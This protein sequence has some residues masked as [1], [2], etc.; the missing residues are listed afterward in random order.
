MVTDQMDEFIELYNPTAVTVNLS[1]YTVSDNQDAYGLGT[2]LL[3]PGEILAL[4]RGTTG[5]V[6]SSDEAVTL[7]YPNGTVLDVLDYPSLKKGWTFQRSPDGGDRARTGRHP[8]PGG[9]NPVPSIVINEVMPDP[10]G[11]N[12]GEQWV[13][14]LNRGRSEELKDMVLTNNEALSYILPSFDIAP[15]ERVLI[16]MGRC[17]ALP[18]HPNMTRTLEASLTE[19]LYSSGD[20]LEL[21]DR[22]GSTL[23][24]IAWGVSKHIEG[25]KGSLGSLSWDGKVWDAISGSMSDKG[26]PNPS[27]ISNKSLSRSPDG[28]DTD[29]TIDLTTHMGFLGSSPGWENDIDP[30]ILFGAVPDRIEIEKGGAT[31]LS[32][33]LSAS[34][35]MTGA[36]ELDQSLSNDNWTLVGPGGSEY[37]LGPGEVLEVDVSLS[38][39]AD[40]AMGHT[41][42]LVLRAAWTSWEFLTS[43]LMID[44]VIP[45][46]ELYLKDLYCT[47][48]GVTA[49]MVPEGALIDVGGKLCG[50]GEVP[51]PEAAVSVSIFNT[52]SGPSAPSAR[53]NSVVFKDL[54]VTSRRSF[55]FILD[56][57]GLTG[58]TSLLLKIDP[59]DLIEESDE[60]NNEAL[61]ELTV[62][63]AP[64]FQGQG[65]LRLSEVLWNTTV[66]GCFVCIDNTGSSPAE[67]SGFMLGNGDTVA[68]FPNDCWLGPEEKALVIWGEDAEGRIPAGSNLFRMDGKGLVGNRMTLSSGLPDLSRSG[69]LRLLT[70]WRVPVDEVL[71][72]RGGGSGD[73]CLPLF[74]GPVETTY[75]TVLKRARALDGSF[76]DTNTTLDW[77]VEPMNAGIGA[78]LI[79]PKPGGSGEFLVIDGMDVDVDLSGAC[80]SCRGRVAV[81]PN[82]TRTGRDGLISVSKDP[83]QFRSVQGVDP[84]LTTGWEVSSV[85]GTIPGCRVTGYEELLLPNDNAELLLLDRGNRLLDRVAWGTD[86]TIPIGKAPYDTVLWRSFP[87]SGHTGPWRVLCRGTDPAYSL[88]GMGR[89]PITF[90][91]SLG[92]L[93]LTEIADGDTTVQLYTPYL[94]EGD[95]LDLLLNVLGTGTE[96]EV[97]LGCQPWEDVGSSGVQASDGD[98]VL[99]AC[100]AVSDSG[101]RLFAPGT[102]SN[103][104]QYTPFLVSGNRTV[105]LYDHG[106]GPDNY[107]DPILPSVTLELGDNTFSLPALG[108]MMPDLEM[109]DI[110]SILSSMPISLSEAGPVDVATSFETPAT[111]LKGMSCTF[112]SQLDTIGGGPEKEV[113]VLHN[114]GPLDVVSLLDLAKEGSV[115]R[116][117]LNPREVHPSSPGSEGEPASFNEVP[118]HKLDLDELER[119]VLEDSIR[120][121]RSASEQG[122]D[123]EARVL[124]VECGLF[125][126]SG[127]QVG[128]GTVQLELP[129]AGDGHRAA[130]RL[131]GPGLSVFN[132]VMGS[133]WA[134][135]HQLPLEMGWG[136]PHRDVEGPSPTVRVQEVFPDTYLVDDP[137]EYVALMNTGGSAVD[138]SGW[139]LSDDEGIGLS[140]DGTV[141]LPEGSVVGPGAMFFIARDHQCFLQQNGHIPDLSMHNCSLSDRVLIC[142]GDMRL[143]NNGDTILLRDTTGTV[144]DSVIYGSSDPLPFGGSYSPAGSWSGPPAPLPGWGNILHREQRTYGGPSSDTGTREDWMGLRPRVPGQSRFGPFTECEVESISTGYCPDSGSDLLSSII[145][146]SGR[147]LD[148][149]VYELTSE[150]VTSAL[151]GAVARGVEVRVIMEGSPVGGRTYGSDLRVNE[152][153]LSGAKVRYMTMDISKGIRDRYSYDH[154]KYMVSD[155][156]T[157]LISSDN[158]KD[159]SFPLP[160]LKGAC[161]GTRGWVML[162]ESV[163]LSQQLAAVFEEDWNGPDMVDGRTVIGEMTAPEDGSAPSE[164]RRGEGL[165]I[166]GGSTVKESAKA[167]L[168]ISPDHISLEGNRLLQAIDGAEKE[169]LVEAMS[170]D[171]DYLTIGTNASKVREYHGL[172]IPGIAWPNPYVTALLEAAM[173]GVDIKV[174][175]DGSDF[176]GDS[177]PDNQRTVDSL[178]EAA[179]ELDMLDRFHVRL[180]PAE[181]PDLERKID[182]VHNKGMVIDSRMVWTSSFNIG[183]TSALKNREVGV[184]VTSEKVS[185]LFRSV[186]MFDWGGTLLGEDLIR[187]VHYGPAGASRT[188]GVKVEL[189]LNGGSMPEAGSELVIVPSLLWDRDGPMVDGRTM[190]GTDDINGTEVTLVLPDL[191]ISEPNELDLYLLSGERWA[192]ILRFKVEP[193]DK[194]AVYDQAPW[195]GNDLV[196][197]LGSVVLAIAITAFLELFLRRSKRGKGPKKERKEEE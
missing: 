58:G 67:L 171:I 147:S 29:R 177:V 187:S 32:V 133:L 108:W 163:P 178:L 176:D 18:P 71:L 114:G 22:D 182:F 185:E 44:L 57:L 146:G 61:W 150:W 174:L 117:L 119:T 154:A 193:F 196:P 170:M 16:A 143:S 149:N 55:S 45:S 152:L 162:L 190:V 168:L 1:G 100:R 94:Q 11:S 166:F 35:N 109:V 115:V 65:S 60:M 27:A 173:R 23:D 38:A 9:S 81:L 172:T 83:D 41:C 136:T 70:R 179:G 161:S 26:F 78:L 5:L 96:V 151:T 51:C 33:M 74:G 105:I 101:G 122:L 25:P 24:Y 86:D 12:S 129:S 99:R 31:T 76:I 95:L 107:D 183:P 120:T 30:T 73:G 188:K 156:R 20:D 186:F 54:T 191:D 141:M 164:D 34:F 77:T 82:G 124:P 194:D 91:L 90:D 93:D 139:T 3:G 123:L 175:L 53:V 72:H 39:P 47:F 68:S 116:L 167:T 126:W 159:S 113:W 69:S 125:D 118:S 66:S 195:Y 28:T 106:R 89:G 15:G 48:E 140:S 135:S 192:H 153:L 21:K 137:D 87:E 56:T 19:T 59:F 148:V 130:L 7:R 165:Y 4:F 142:R 63:P 8:T 84:D 62:Y 184:L 42:R 197:L 134:D 64:S 111:V 181:R 75:G 138:I 13:E 17:D 131:S 43:C 6:L 36:L 157:V 189:T 14:L 79:S 103:P 127:L 40:L 144:V 88:F 110:T 158:L 92:S 132:E 160:L 121:V 128:S 102:A 112:R 85:S 145:A 97:F 80:L 104:D 49:G 169:V 98:S 180:H 2:V 52:S 155:G 46:P 10:E 37:M 50:G